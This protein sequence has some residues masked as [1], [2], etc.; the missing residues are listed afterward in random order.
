MYADNAATQIPTEP[1][2]L[3]A[4][5]ALQVLTNYARHTVPNRDNPHPDVVGIGVITAPAGATSERDAEFTVYAVTEPPTKH[6]VVDAEGF[7]WV[8]IEDDDEGDGWQRQRIEAAGEAKIMVGPPLADDW[9]DMLWYGPL[10]PLGDDGSTAMV[11]EYFPDGYDNG[12]PVG[13]SQR[14]HY[15]YFLEN[16]ETIRSNRTIAPTPT[17][18]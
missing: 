3:D 12:R 11:V 16:L 9:E 13:V 15:M 17:A 18:E 7:V 10:T 1:T 14:Y 2:D 4:N 8:Y 6:P 5:I